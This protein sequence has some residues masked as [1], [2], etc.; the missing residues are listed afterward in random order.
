MDCISEYLECW[1]IEIVCKDNRSDM[2]NEWPVV[3]WRR[4]IRCFESFAV[5]VL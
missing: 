2:A 5:G 3:S 4:D 1:Y